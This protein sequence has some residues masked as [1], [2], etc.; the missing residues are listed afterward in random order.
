MLTRAAKQPSS[1]PCS[2]Q[3]SRVHVFMMR[4]KHKKHNTQCVQLVPSSASPDHRH[5]RSEDERLIAAV[6]ST[7]GTA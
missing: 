4:K 1:F 5:N 2:D 6:S 3:V 7:V